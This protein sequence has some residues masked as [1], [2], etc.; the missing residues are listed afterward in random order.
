MVLKRKINVPGSLRRWFAVLLFI[1]AAAVAQPTPQTAAVGPAAKKMETAPVHLLSE[2]EDKMEAS[3]FA[4]G[5]AWALR[6]SG[7]GRSAHTINTDDPVIFLLQ[8]D[9]TV[10]LRATAVQGFDDL[11][12]T[13]SYRHEYSV[14]QQDLEMLSRSRVQA[15]R[16]YTVIGF[17]DYTLDE[18]ASASLHS[19]T[20]DF[21]QKLDREGLLKKVV[22]TEP[23]FPG[24]SAVLLSF[25][26]KNLKPL[27]AL[28][29][30]GQKTARVEISV[31]EEGRIENVAIKQSAGA[32]YDAEILRMISRMPRWKAGLADGNPIKR[33]V[34]INLRFYQAPE[35]VKLALD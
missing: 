12:S 34:V 32:V 21:L 3:F 7:T 26:N 10:T 27:P 11:D 15:V 9:S 18:P 20:T 19:L 29:A 5:K 28:P 17:D 22:V 23:A 2:E 33:D 35:G 16:K 13:R 4:E 25:L 6:L 14:Q 24:G 1:P 30:N 31:D 8:N